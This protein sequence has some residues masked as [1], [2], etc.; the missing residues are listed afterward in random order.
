MPFKTSPRKKPL[1]CYLTDH[2][3]IALDQCAMREGLTRSELLRKLIIRY[4]EPLSPSIP[5]AQT[6]TESMVFDSPC[7]TP[8]CLNAAV[9]GDTLCKSCSLDRFT[10]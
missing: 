6:T 2:E 7:M 3:I 8:D 9:K 4:V 1:T 10:E 5:V